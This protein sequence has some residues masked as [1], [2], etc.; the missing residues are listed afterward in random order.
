[1]YHGKQ[2]FKG[3]FSIRNLTG[4]CSAIGSTSKPRTFSTLGNKFQTIYVEAI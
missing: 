3:I 2:H 1:M 4:L